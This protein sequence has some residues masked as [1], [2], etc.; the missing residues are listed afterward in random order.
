MDAGRL[1][2]QLSLCLKQEHI[3]LRQSAFEQGRALGD[4]IYKRYTT[5]DDNLNAQFSE[6]LSYVTFMGNLTKAKEAQ[7]QLA[8]DQKTLEGFKNLLNTAKFKIKDESQ[9]SNLVFNGKP[10]QT[11][12]SHHT[13]LVKLIEGN[14][15]KQANLFKLISD[16]E[17]ETLKE[18]EKYNE[19]LVARLNDQ[20]A[21]L[22]KYLD[23]INKNS[24]L[25]EAETLPEH[26]LSELERIKKRADKTST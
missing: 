11:S 3:K 19:M 5:I 21:E 22:E 15:D 1:K 4:D 10:F 24:D 2:D 6:L 23:D 12:Q 16:K 7:D 14:A 20:A 9:N 13:E 17:A 8:V 18:K 25:N 26:A